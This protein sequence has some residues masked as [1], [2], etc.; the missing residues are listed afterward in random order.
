MLFETEGVEEYLSGVILDPET[1]YQK[2]SSL[3]DEGGDGKRFVEV[4][5]ERDI[6]VGVKPHLKAYELPGTNGDTVMQGLDS[7][8]VRCREYALAGAKFAKWRSPI[9]VDKSTGR[10]T[11][12]AI[13]S[14]TNDLARYALICQSEGLMPI[15]EPDVVLSGDHTLQESV[16]VDIRV[17]STLFRAMIEHGV[18]MSGTTLKTNLVNPGGTT[19]RPSPSTRSPKPTSLS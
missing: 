11:D 12:L 18:Y 19:P 6:V 16:D 7:L 3:G 17:R 5:E 2:S 15:V 10:P 1:L 9:T 4:L 14:N 8:A 13:R